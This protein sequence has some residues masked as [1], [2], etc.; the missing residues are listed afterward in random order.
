MP[1]NLFWRAPKSRLIGNCSCVSRFRNLQTKPA[2]WVSKRS[3]P[4]TLVYTKDGKGRH[5]HP[6][7][8]NRLRRRLPGFAGLSRHFP[9]PG[10]KQAPRQN[11]N[12]LCSRPP[13]NCVVGAGPP[14]CLAGCLFLRYC[15]KGSA[16]TLHNAHRPGFVRPLD[17]GQNRW[18]TGPGHKR[19]PRFPSLLQW[20]PPHDGCLPPGIA[21]S[22]P[23]IY[24][25]G[26]HGFV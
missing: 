6:I 12:A 21:R 5:R 8:I 15:R 9:D 7:K 13:T 19:S 10:E 26:G 3:P 20:L 24:A 25:V 22:H 11:E 17:V 23:S 2:R 4:C 16:S 18:S 1:G 14:G